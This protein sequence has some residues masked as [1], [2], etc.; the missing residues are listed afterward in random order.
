MVDHNETRELDP[1][2]VREALGEAGERDTGHSRELIDPSRDREARERL[3]EP[4]PTGDGDQGEGGEP[5]G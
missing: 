4:P 3:E 5:S 2:R 1:E